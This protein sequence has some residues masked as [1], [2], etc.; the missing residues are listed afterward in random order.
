MITF[1]KAKE[2]LKSEYKGGAISMALET[3]GYFVFE[4]IPDKT[5]YKDSFTD[6]LVGVDKK[7][8][9]IGTY[10]PFLNR[11]DFKKAKIL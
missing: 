11:E 4:V 1:N 10:H 8:G 5:K 9:K 2:K 6:S 7:T 3:P